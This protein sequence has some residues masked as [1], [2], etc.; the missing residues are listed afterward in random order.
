MRSEDKIQWRSIRGFEGL[1]EVSND[2]RVRGVAR[3]VPF[4]N[5]RGVK[6][7][8][9]KTKEVRLSRCQKGYL[10][11]V[12]FDRTHGKNRRRV[13]HLVLEA[14]IGPRPD[15]MLALHKDDNKLNNHIS[16][17][18]WG[19][20]A[21]NMLDRAFNNGTLCGESNPMA[22][23]TEFKVR[24]IL[25]LLA[26]TNRTVKDQLLCNLFGTTKNQI[27]S[28]KQGRKWKHVSIAGSR[29]DAF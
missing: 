16:N 13:H 6:G 24:C 7:K 20:H 4:D 19:T 18:Y 25:G 27:Q 3:F 12:L 1:Y 26:A 23:L 21:D 5:G 15:G 29:N 28:I 2:G 11:V 9:Y 22:K 14:F 17:L 8:T 10:D